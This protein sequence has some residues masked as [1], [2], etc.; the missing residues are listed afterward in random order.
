M[1]DKQKPVKQKPGKKKTPDDGRGVLSWEPAKPKKPKKP[2]P[3]ETETAP[4]LA[5]LVH[6]VEANTKRVTDF[7]EA[8]TLP[9]QS[10]LKEIAKMP[11]T[12][13]EIKA[14]LQAADQKLDAAFAEIKGEIAVLQSSGVSQA[15]LDAL[16]QVAVNVADKAQQLS[17][18]IP[19]EVG[20]EPAPT[21]P[22]VTPTPVDPTTIPS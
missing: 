3:S 5:C 16:N 7:L 11:K 10:L 8:F 17:D 1:P 12:F 9:L 22:D 18:A 20:G 21:P 15:D 4:D 19:N 6:A 14:A 2:T 13:A